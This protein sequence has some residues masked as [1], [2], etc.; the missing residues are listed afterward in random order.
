MLILFQA[1]QAQARDEVGLVQ[2]EVDVAQLIIT[3]WISLHLIIMVE[4]VLVVSTIE[5][6]VAFLLSQLLPLSK[7]TACCYDNKNTSIA[8]HTIQVRSLKLEESVPLEPQ[9][10]VALDMPPE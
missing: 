8:W 5:T 10:Y 4:V 3:N 7:I 9:G 6:G 1:H 2:A